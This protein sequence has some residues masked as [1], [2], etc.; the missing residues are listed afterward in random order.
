MAC[1]LNPP[2]IALTTL[3][4]SLAPHAHAQALPDPTRPPGNA[5]FSGSGGYGSSGLQ[6]IIR[7]AGQKPRALIHGEI[8]A[9][10]GKVGGVDGSQRLVAVNADS[11]VLL[12]ADGNR[13]TLT[14]TPGI[15][16]SPAK[17]KPSATR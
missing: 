12:D 10:G 16:K 3:L 11:V 13:E 1:R 15:S 4:A 9:L 7:P 8:V 2:A 17:N 5:E 14:L 6:S